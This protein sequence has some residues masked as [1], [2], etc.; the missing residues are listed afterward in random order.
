MAIKFLGNV[1]R[2]IQFHVLKFQ[3]VTLNVQVFL[4]NISLQKDYKTIKF[5]SLPLDVKLV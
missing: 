1:E 3:V 4:T 2:L 5:Y